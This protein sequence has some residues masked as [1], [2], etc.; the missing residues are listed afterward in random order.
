VTQTPQP[1]QQCSIALWRGYVSAQ[2]YVRQKDLDGA[3]GI[4]QAFRTWRPPWE[5]RKPLAEDP[6]VLAALAALEADLISSGWKRMRRAPGSE[7][8]ERRFRRGESR[9]R[10]PRQLRPVDNGARSSSVGQEQADEPRRERR[11][12][13]HADA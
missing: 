13:R 9:T 7:W 6:A 10:P 5:E 11:E 1:T 8:Y 12:H 4:S 2:F 3:L